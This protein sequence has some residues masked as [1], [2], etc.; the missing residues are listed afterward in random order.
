MVMG[1]TDKPEYNNRL[2]QIGKIS[3]NIVGLNAFK[4]TAQNPANPLSQEIA[5]FASDPIASNRILSDY[6][7]RIA[8]DD[9]QTFLDNEYDQHELFSQAMIGVIL[10]DNILSEIRKL[11]Q[12]TAHKVRGKIQWSF[13]SI[14]GLP[15]SY[16]IELMKFCGIDNVGHLV[17]VHFKMNSK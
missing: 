14:Q 2:I 1:K 6:L 15:S 3:M 16:L 5:L 12:Q 17:D 9:L 13:D 11:G 8:N 4:N 7:V 10:Q